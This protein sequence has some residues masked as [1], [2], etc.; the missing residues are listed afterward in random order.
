LLCN[1]QTGKSIELEVNENIKLDTKEGFIYEKELLAK[2]FNDVDFMEPFGE[3]NFF[4][5]ISAMSKK[6]WTIEGAD[7]H[8]KPKLNRT[9]FR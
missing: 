7:P 8:Y 1:L 3:D 6:L 4:K 9:T 5:S 2:H